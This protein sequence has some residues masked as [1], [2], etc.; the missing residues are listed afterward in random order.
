MII[1]CRSGASTKHRKNNTIGY[2]GIGFKSVVNYSNIVH[3]YSGDIKATFSKMLTQKE[4]PEAENVPLI[5]I[6]HNFEGNEYIKYIYEYLRNEYTTIFIFEVNNN[7]LLDEIE[8]FDSSCMLF[9]RNIKEI[10]FDS[11][12]RENVFLTRN[13]QIE[14]NI[15]MVQLIGTEDNQNWLVY[16]D[17]KNNVMETYMRQETENRKTEALRS[18]LFVACFSEVNN[19][20]P[21]WGYYAA[22]HKGICLGYNLYELVKKYQCMPVIYSD[23]LIFYREDSSEKNILANTLTKSDEWIHEKEW[24]IVI[25]DDIN[26]GKSGI[27]K[28]FVLP[29]EIYIGC[30]QQ[31]TVAEN[32]NNRMLHSKKENEMYADLDEILQWAENNYIDV[33]MPI[34][35]RKEYK[36]IDRALRLI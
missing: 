29:R 6:P 19:S 32:N 1:L 13:N 16:N 4:I 2:R 14:D 24:R 18:S 36:M 5:R 28:D 20:F 8:M 7:C 10:I 12:S 11:K 21:M 35:S 17:S 22:D 34:I 15:K 33:Y 31:E 27:I 30:R 25:K 23:K 3:L 9:L 26:I